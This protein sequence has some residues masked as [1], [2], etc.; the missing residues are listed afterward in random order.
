MC[1]RVVPGKVVDSSTISWSRRTTPASAWAA[2]SSG[3]RSGS[4]LRVS[5]VGTHTR[6]ASASCS[7]TARVVN[8]HESEHG[9]QPLVGDVLDR[10]AAGREL[11][12]APVVDVDADHL[13]ARLG[14]RDGQRQAD[15]S[16]S[17]DADAQ[18]CFL[19]LREGHGPRVAPGAD[20]VVPGD[21]SGEPC[22]GRM[23]PPAQSLAGRRGVEAQRRRLDAR[24]PAARPAR[25]AASARERGRRPIAPAR[26]PSG[27][28]FHACAHSLDSWRRSA[29]RR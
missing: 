11:G 4:R 19:D 6:I 28:K 15:I 29:S 12:D 24:R 25:R 22:G 21:G 27:P 23:R 8:W 7:S 13:L 9:L 1:S 16:Q 18:R 10:R 17:D 20:L 3:P 5:G 14:E 26:A 2:D